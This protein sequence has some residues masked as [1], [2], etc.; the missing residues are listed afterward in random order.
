[1]YRNDIFPYSS[2]NHP[3]GRVYTGAVVSSI[4]FII[5]AFF[6]VLPLLSSEDTWI[7]LGEDEEE[8]LES[9]PSSIATTSTTTTT[10]ISTSA[11]TFLA[12]RNSKPQMD[13]FEQALFG[14]NYLIRERF[15]TVS[16]VLYESQSLITNFSECKVGN[17]LFSHVPK[18]GGRTLVFSFTTRA[19]SNPLAGKLGEVTVALNNI[20]SIPRFKRKDLKL[21]IS[22]GHHT[23][24][25]V[26]GREM[27]H[28]KEK[29]TIPRNQC[30]I[31]IIKCLKYVLFTST[32]KGN[33]LQ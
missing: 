4:I 7:N 17:I 2:S 28:F 31:D 15:Y 8:A 16:D 5:L 29:L 30:K 18:T 21:Y 10:A 22:R 11:S 6:L 3:M 1:M 24:I 9:T 32:F 25:D 20:M 12:L 33:F 13:P 26:G 23:V 19:P 14:D 27:D